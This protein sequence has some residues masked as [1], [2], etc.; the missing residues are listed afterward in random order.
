MK[1][2]RSASQ[3]D[4]RNPNVQETSKTLESSPSAPLYPKPFHK[5]DTEASSPRP[6]SMIKKP[7]GDKLN[8]PLERCLFPLFSSIFLSWTLIQLSIRQPWI[9]MKEKHGRSPSLHSESLPKHLGSDRFEFK[10][11]TD[12]PDSFCLSHY[13]IL[14]FLD[15]ILATEETYHAY[16]SAL[17]DVFII[18][19][20]DM[21]DSK[22]MPSIKELDSLHLFP[23]SLVFVDFWFPNLP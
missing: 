5:E 20:Y 12:V 1:K 16:L 15:D 19:L 14:R 22:E 23:F 8:K 17:L 4:L 9:V 2:K 3:E 11:L 18:P 21:V 7:S 6:R 10:Y 13:D